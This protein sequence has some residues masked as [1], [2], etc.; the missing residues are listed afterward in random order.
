MRQPGGPQSLLRSPGTHSIHGDQARTPLTEVL[1]LVHNAL[2]GSGLR[3]HT[4][5]C[6][7]ELPPKTRT[8]PAPSMWKAKA[9]GCNASKKQLSASHC[10]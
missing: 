1:M 6:P 8:A 4:N 10:E 2:V 3:C 7:W 9:S 5:H